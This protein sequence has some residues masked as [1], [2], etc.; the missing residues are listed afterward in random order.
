MVSTLRNI[1]TAALLGSACLR[2]TAIAQ[3]DAPATRTNLDLLRML[4]GTVAAASFGPSVPTDTQ[5]V[6]VTVLPRESAWIVED[7][8]IDALHRH[9]AKIAQRY[10]RYEAEFGLVRLRVNYE[11]IR[12][13]GMFGPKLVDRDV[14]VTLHARI[15]DT[16]EGRLLHSGDVSSEHRDTVA[17]SGI[18]R[19]ENSMV[20]ATH[21]VLPSE[22]FFTSL[23]EPIIM[24]GAVAVAVV[25]LFT[26]R[27]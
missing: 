9:G 13:D 8:I 17:V 22:G 18:E 15:E 12:R 7:S 21:G 1:V 2:T 14:A 5:G 10:G 16:R 24:L 3:E 26:V 19:L 4:A 23:A 11:N 20:P 25:L 27:S 6:H